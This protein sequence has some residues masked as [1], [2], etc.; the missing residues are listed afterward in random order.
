VNSV[1]NVGIARNG[2]YYPGPQFFKSIVSNQKGKRLK[3]RRKENVKGKDFH[4]FC[5]FDANSL[6]RNCLE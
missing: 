2:F 6:S 3:K 5:L 4:F 1:P